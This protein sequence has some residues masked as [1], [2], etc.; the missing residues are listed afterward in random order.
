M[1]GERTRVK[2]NDVRWAFSEIKVDVEGD[3]TPA[4]EWE[5]FL[6]EKVVSKLPRSK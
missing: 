2:W 5:H 6:R 3:E 1:R 4:L